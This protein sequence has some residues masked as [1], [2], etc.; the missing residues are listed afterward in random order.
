M[1]REKGSKSKLEKTAL[2]IVS[3]VMI[4]ARHV[5][6]VTEGKQTCKV[7]DVKYERDL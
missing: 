6:H 1:R 2:C 5:A 3:S 7:F 4:L